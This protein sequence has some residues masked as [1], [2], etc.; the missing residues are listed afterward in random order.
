VLQQVILNLG[1]RHSV[2]R[3]LISKAPRLRVA[4]RKEAHK[5]GCKLAARRVA[6]LQLHVAP[7]R[8]DEGWVEL[9]DV[10]GGHY[11]DATFLRHDAVDG[12]EQ[13]G[14]A[15]LDGIRGRIL[16]L[17][18]DCVHVFQHDQRTNRYHTQNICEFAICH[19]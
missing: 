1:H 2:L 16:A 6:D 10:V 5:H 8:A 17:H 3:N 4:P 13:T 12:V 15:Q 19:V 9:F 14:E 11:E 18:K 7:T